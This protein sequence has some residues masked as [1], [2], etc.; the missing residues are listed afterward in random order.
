MQKKKILDNTQ[1]LNKIKRIS[2]QIIESYLDSSKIIIC[3]IEKNGALLAQKICA[4]LNHITKKNIIFCKIEI[5][6]SNPTENIQLSIN[7]EV[8]ENQSI[9][10][11]DDVLNSGK[12]LI[13]A[14]KYFLDIEVKSIKT[15]VL[16]NRSHKKFPI[17]ADFKGLNLSSSLQNHVDVIFTNDKIEGF[18]F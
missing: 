2:L 5:N 15:A 8:C 3:G 16:V 12:T 17:S 13:Y 6:K 14:V 1:I 7:K 10:I 9:V 4:E 11:V 18:L